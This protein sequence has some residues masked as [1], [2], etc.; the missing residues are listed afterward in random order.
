MKIS[1]LVPTVV[2]GVEKLTGDNSKQEKERVLE[3][4]KQ[5][6]ALFYVVFIPKDC[7]LF[8]FGMLSEYK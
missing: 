2:P 6:L 3:K 5:G 8:A 7:S 1:N 4:F